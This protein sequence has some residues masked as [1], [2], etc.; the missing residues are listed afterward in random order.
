MKIA[1]FSLKRI[2]LNFLPHLPSKDSPF[3][4]CMDN[5]MSSKNILKPTSHHDYRLSIFG[6]FVIIIF[7]NFL[8]GL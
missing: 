6:V 2:L 1:L 3:I 7:A 8:Y 5:A 4:Q